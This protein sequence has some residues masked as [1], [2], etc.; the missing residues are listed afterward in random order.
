MEWMET[1]WN[2]RKL[3]GASSNKLSHQKLNMSGVNLK[4]SRPT[5]SGAFEN[6]ACLAI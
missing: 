3:F 1:G 5:V 4:G 6:F 2:L